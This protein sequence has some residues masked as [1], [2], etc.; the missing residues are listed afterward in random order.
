VTVK[1][2]VGMG[3]YGV[4][5]WFRRLGKEDI[6]VVMRMIDQMGLTALA[7]VSIS[8]LSGG[9]QQRVFLARALAQEPHILILDEPLNGVDVTTQE[10]TFQILDRLRES[11]VTVLFATHDLNLAA[12]QFDLV[13]LIS[14]TLIAYGPPASV[15]C[16]DNIQRAFGGRALVLGGMVVADHCCPE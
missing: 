15:L 8:D 16:Q 6:R 7:G 12:T 13:A 11:A 3:R 14:R 4:R 5:G 9:Q 2:V 10:T 1:D